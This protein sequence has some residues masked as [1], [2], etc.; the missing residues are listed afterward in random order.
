MNRCHLELV[1]GHEEQGAAL[2]PVVV[3]PPASTAGTK[4]AARSLEARREREETA[5]IVRASLRK[6]GITNG[7]VARACK[8]DVKLVRMW[9]SGGKDIPVRHLRKLATPTQR[10]L[11]DALAAEPVRKVAA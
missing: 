10:A 1:A 4:R 9:L 7:Q 3:G 11:Y 8:V 2:G 5:A 6:R